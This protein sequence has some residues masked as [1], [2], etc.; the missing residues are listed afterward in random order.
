MAGARGRRRRRVEGMAGRRLRTT[1]G[2]AAQPAAGTGVG[3]ADA[4]QGCGAGRAGAAGGGS[5]PRAGVLR[6]RVWWISCASGVAGVATERNGAMAD[7]ADVP[8][9]DDLI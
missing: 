9:R 1:A 8:I 6:R 5:A 3:G 7:A 4:P 2:G